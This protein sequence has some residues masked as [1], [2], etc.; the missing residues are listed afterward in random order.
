MAPRK[1]RKTAKQKAAE[2]G[3]ITRIQVEAHVEAATADDVLFPRAQARDYDM[4]A[5][6]RVA[7]ESFIKNLGMKIGQKVSDASGLH[8]IPSW[9]QHKSFVKARWRAVAQAVIDAATKKP[10]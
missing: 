6:A 5:A 9:D 4:D 2:D 1:P 3:A 8:R 10:A 7:Y